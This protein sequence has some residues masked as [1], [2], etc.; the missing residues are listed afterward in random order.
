MTAPTDFD[1]FASGVNLNSGSFSAGAYA[2]LVTG[3]PSWATVNAPSHETRNGLEGKLFSGVAD[4]RCIADMSAM[5]EAT[6][7]TVAQPLNTSS[8][9]II[10]GTF[11]ANNT[12]SM[13]TVAGLLRTFCYF[14]NQAQVSGADT[15]R[16]R[17]YTSSWHPESG[18]LY[19]Q[20]DDNTPVSSTYASDK[21]NTGINY[22]EAA[23]GSMRTTYFSG[24]IAR[25]L[26]FD[27]ALHARD[28]A[29]L[30]SLIATEMASIGL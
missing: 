30:Q 14:N 7:L 23:I 24:W 17:V 20:V 5:H 27:R 1:S 16:A 12:W 26:I 21:A 22:F 3:S 19:A 6:I 2:N 29:G 4:D 11:A 15:T 28:N 18:T 8:Q 13:Y 9:Y 10:G 25:V